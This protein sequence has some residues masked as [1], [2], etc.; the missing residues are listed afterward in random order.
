MI[1]KI[2]LTDDSHDTVS[3][4]ILGNTVDFTDEFSIMDSNFLLDEQKL[5]GVSDFILKEIAAKSK[6]NAEIADI[7]CKMIEDIIVNDILDVPLREIIA[8]RILLN[9]DI[10]M[11]LDLLRKRMYDFKISI[12]SKGILDF[13]I[14]VL[15]EENSIGCKKSTISFAQG[16]ATTILCNIL[17]ILNAN[18]YDDEE[19]DSIYLVNTR[20]DLDSDITTSI[21]SDYI[22]MSIDDMAKIVNEYANAVNRY[23]SRNDGYDTG[24]ETITIVKPDQ[25]VKIL[26]DIFENDQI[27]RER[28]DY[29]ENEDVEHDTDDDGFCVI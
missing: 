13:I 25:N 5:Y 22:F 9:K 20:F 15:S 27:M 11:V 18:I 7:V 8:A 14:F 12:N 29:L 10:M 3:K 21:L 4:I 28:E 24:I 23:L 6:T 17:A 1:S 26:H 2:N 19:K 16:K